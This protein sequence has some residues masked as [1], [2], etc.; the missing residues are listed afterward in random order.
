MSSVHVVGAGPAGSFAALSALKAG[1][2][3]YLSEE[4]ERIGQPVHCSGLVSA[5]GLKQMDDVVPCKKVIRNPIYRANLHGAN[6]CFSL[7]YAQPKAYVIERGK[8]DF[9]AARKFIDA[10]GK[11]LSGHGVRRLEDLKSRN[12]IGA[13]GPI[14]T[15]S[16]LFD[17]PRIRAYTSCWQGDFSYRCIDTGAVEVFFDPRL[18]PGFIGWI[19]PT[20]EETAEIGLGVASAKG[21]H[22]AR[23]QFLSKI[24]LKDKKPE[25]EFSALIPLTVRQKTGKITNGYNVVLAGDAAGQVKAS[26]GGGIFF[27]SSCGRLAG[28][29]FEHP[30]EYEKAWRQKYGLDL[31]LHGLLRR[32]INSLPS[33]GVDLWLAS[34]KA[35]RFE[36]LLAES[37]EMD[38]YSKMLSLRSLG[39]WAGAWAGNP[40]KKSESRKKD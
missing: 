7:S 32:G 29:L 15:I 23:N 39:A 25:S 14:S 21:L 33:F 1:H 20:S 4:H 13:D 34:M 19:I 37:G 28:Q 26:S 5:S 22:A 31:A 17:F 24:G 11:V 8:F 12:V 35:L 2:D 38:E 27:G 6:S 3:V 16:R 40:R 18:C 10:G 9:L 36:R 30:D